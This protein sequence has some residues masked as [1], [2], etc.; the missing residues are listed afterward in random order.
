MISENGSKAL[1]LLLTDTYFENKTANLKKI[2]TVFSLQAFTNVRR[3]FSVIFYVT[4][5]EDQE[6]L[7]D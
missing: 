2:L 5:N 3:Y 6:K 1:S 4:K 7:I